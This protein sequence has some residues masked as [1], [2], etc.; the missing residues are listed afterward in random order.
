MAQN[1][2]DNQVFFDNYSR[3]DRSVHGLEGAA[4]WPRLRSLLPDVTGLRIL[5]LGCGF[6]WFC[7]WAADHGAGAVR[8]I[9]LSRNMLSRAATMSGEKHANIVYE[10]ADLDGFRARECDEGAYDLV[11][12]SLTLHYLVDLRSLVG[13]VSRM[14]VSGGHF[15][16]SVEH[17]IFTAPSRP[18]FVEDGPAGKV[19][20]PLDDYQ[21]EGER[22]TDWLAD[23]VKKQHRTIATYL[24]MLLDAGFEL[25]GFD[26]W[27]PT[28]GE[29]EAHP[30]WAVENH[31]PMFLLMHAR[32]R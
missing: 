5:D 17:P 18:R 21:R 20:W 31:R 23:G 27:H 1:V 7:R 10:R 30:E 29:L 28:A 25:T 32:Q 22:V 8:G 16:F 19:S 2:Y 26:E 4:E 3:L 12:C 11:F 6:G 13:Q 14:L 24:N 15:V 9:D